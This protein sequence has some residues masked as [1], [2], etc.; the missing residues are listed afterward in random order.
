MA[1]LGFNFLFL[2]SLFISTFYS[3][4]LNVLATKSAL[5]FVVLEF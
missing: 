4:L 5:N 3:L 2:F 1:I